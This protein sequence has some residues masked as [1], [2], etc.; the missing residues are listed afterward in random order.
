M[1]VQFVRH[2]VAPHVFM[3]ELLFQTYEE[4]LA[5][6]PLVVVDQSLTD[7]AGEVL[8]DLRSGRQGRDSTAAET[9]PSGAR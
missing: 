9:I 6:K 3:L 8:L 5:D 1:L 2:A 4:A 7:G